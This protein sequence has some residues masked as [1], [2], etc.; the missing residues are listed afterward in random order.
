MRAP[1][2]NSY[3]FIFTLIL[4]VATAVVLF[5]SAPQPVQAQD[6]VTPT[7]EVQIQIVGGQLADRGEWPW[8]VALIGHTAATYDF[9]HSPGYQFCGGSLID[10]QWVLTAAH[11]ITEDNGSVTVASTIDVVAGIYDLIPPPSEYGFQRRAVTQII[12]HPSY[13]SNTFNN[14]IALLKLSSPITIGGSGATKT[15][16]IPLV[17]SNIGD[18]TGEDSWVTGW[19]NTST[20]ATDI[21][22]EQL[23]EVTFPIIANSVCNNVSHYNG[24]I[25]NNMLCAGI[26]PAGGKDACQGDSGGPLVVGVP[27]SYKLAGIVSWG[28]GCGDPFSPGVYTR[29]S[30]YVSWVATNT[31]LVAPVVSTITRASANP[32]NT[33]SVNFT[34]TFSEAVTGVDAADFYLTNTGASGAAVSG[35]SGSGTSYTVAVNTGSGNGTIRLDLG[36]NDLIKDGNSNPLGG[37]GVNNFTSGETYTIDKTTPTVLSIAGTNPNP[38]SAT[39][40]NFTVTFSELVTGV[41]INAPS[42]FSLTTTGVTG[43]SI[44]GISGSG[45]T[46]TVTVN[47]GSGNGTIQLNVMDNNTIVNII[48]KPLG[49]SGMGDGNFTGGEIYTVDKTAPTISSITRASTNPAAAANINFLV[50]FSEVVTGVDTSDFS[51]NTT[52][53]VGATI[54][55]VN[56]SGATRTVTVNTGSGDGM[57]RLDAIDNDTITDLASNPLG[58]GI[59]SGEVYNINKPDLSAPVLRSPRTSMVTNDTTPTFWWTAVRGGETYE[60]EFAT[61]SAFTTGKSSHNVNSSSY[62]VITPFGNGNYFWHVR[63]Y[64]ASTQPGAWSSLRTFTIDITGP[65]APVLSSPANNAS[66]NRI[67]T[68]K[69]LGAPTAVLYEFQYDDAPDFLTPVYSVTVRS[70]FRRPPAMGIGTYYWHVRAKD[71]AGNWGAWST[72]RT[73]IITGP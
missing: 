3:L 17:P 49:G 16:L 71:A 7:P 4:T 50:T 13:N 63:A 27:G 66:S 5:G 40:I 47:T 6:I 56:G 67:P 23:Y 20:T 37:V 59:T 39:S 32:N 68:F 14:D 72:T 31:D 28:Y 55:G 9:W 22:P 24:A 65:S 18:L 19:G 73:I 36:D 53:V 52:S 60:I 45:S 29:V 1:K 42:D 35:V 10:P 58:G 12:R 46:R 44:S 8:Q 70:I 41:N 51:L 25:T 33:S 15:A 64:N 26:D 54:S 21:Y 43:A 34:V 30:N 48:S 62:T 69:W 11:C 57:I 61:N 2:S 38:T